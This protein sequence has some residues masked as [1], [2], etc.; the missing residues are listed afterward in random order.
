MADL[1]DGG[2]ALLVVKVNYVFARAMCV[3]AHVCVCVCVFIPLASLICRRLRNKWSWVDPCLLIHTHT[4]TLCF[5]FQSKTWRETMCQYCTSCW[6]IS[7]VFCVSDIFQSHSPDRVADQCFVLFWF[8]LLFTFAV[9]KKRKNVHVH[10]CHV[11]ICSVCV[12]LCVCVFLWL[13]PCSVRPGWC[14]DRLW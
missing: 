6:F 3:C 12:C 10:I 5:F 9:K 14:I 8:C 1:Y 2:E 7:L 13:M 4:H 11:H